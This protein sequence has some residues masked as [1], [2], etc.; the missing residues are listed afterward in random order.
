M[1]KVGEKVTIPIGSKTL[2]SLF[3]ITADSKDMDTLGRIIYDIIVMH[4]NVNDHQCNH[5]C[6]T[7]D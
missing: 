6:S 2:P 4:K 1:G 3:L 5:A 7:G